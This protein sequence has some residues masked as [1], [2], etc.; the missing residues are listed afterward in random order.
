[1]SFTSIYIAHILHHQIQA[2]LWRLAMHFGLHV[3]CILGA[4]GGSNVSLFV[5]Y[6]PIVKGSCIISHSPLD[7]RSIQYRITS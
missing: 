2:V 7:T 5:Y 6:L 1:M 4:M 3:M